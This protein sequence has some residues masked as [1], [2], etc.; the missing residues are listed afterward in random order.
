MTSYSVP[1]IAPFPCTLYSKIPQVSSIWSPLSLETTSVQILFFQ[2]KETIFSKSL[3][4]F[5]LPN[6]TVFFPLNLKKKNQ[7]SFD[8]NFQHYLNKSVFLLFEMLSSLGLQDFIYLK[9]YMKY[10]SYIWNDPNL[11]SFMLF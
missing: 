2:H 8:L 3:I 1:F 5:M 10:I 6:P 4:N 9:W 7:S 11:G